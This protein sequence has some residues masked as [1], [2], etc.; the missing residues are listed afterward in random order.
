MP[1]RM[2]IAALPLALC[3]ASPALA[4]ADAAVPEPSSMLL[5]GLGVAGVLIGRR[6]GR[7]PATET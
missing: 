7:R 3:G 1:F 6:A 4:Q 5:L 2:A